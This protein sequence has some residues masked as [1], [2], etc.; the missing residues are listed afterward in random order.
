MTVQANKVNYPGDIPYFDLIN[1]AS[2]I[3]ELTDVFDQAVKG[4]GFDLFTLFEMHS[5]TLHWR[6]QLV[7]GTIPDFFWDE[8]WKET[9]IFEAPLMRQAKISTKPFKFRDVFKSTDLSW[10]EKKAIQNPINAGFTDGLIVPLKGRRNRMAL[11]GITG[12]TEHL[13]E[14]DIWSLW[15]LSSTLYQRACSLPPYSEETLLQAKP[16]VLTR[17]QRECLT[18]VAMGKT[19]E[20]VAKELG[21]SKRTIGFHIEN[22][23]ERLGVRTRLQAVVTATENLDILV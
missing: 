8:F 15:C 2:N 5:I 22:A 10:R 16:S 4:L 1:G 3:A 13:S 12:N 11:V 17:R 9:R 7:F 23:K 6:K 19:D 20:E 14:R 21:L 18:W